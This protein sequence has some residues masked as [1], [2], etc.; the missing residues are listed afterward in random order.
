MAVEIERLRQGYCRQSKQEARSETEQNIRIRLPGQSQAYHRAKPGWQTKVR[1]PGGQSGRQ[2]G[3]PRFKHT[4]WDKVGPESW[5]TN[6]EVVPGVLSHLVTPAD[7]HSSWPWLRGWPHTPSVLISCRVL[8]FN[9][10]TKLSDIKGNLK[11]CV[12]VAS[13]LYV[14]L[15]RR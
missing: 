15:M 12:S 13:C 7:S 11:P 2:W 10:N 14:L 6:W 8:T 4:D 1:N 9:F 5:I 3:A